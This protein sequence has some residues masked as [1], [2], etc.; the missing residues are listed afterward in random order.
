MPYSPKLLGE[1][2]TR[3]GRPTVSVVIPAR[4][5]AANLRLV[6]PTL[7][8]VHE[9]ILVDGHSCDG[10][11]EAA[12]TVLP[13]IRVVRQTRRGKGNALACGFAAATGDV[14]VMFD[15]DG[16]ADPA[17][18][19]RFVGALERGADLAKGSRFGTAAGPAGGSQDLT[20]WRRLGN[21]GLNLI[22]N[23]LFRTGFSDLCYGYNAFWRDLLPVLDLPAPERSTPDGRMLWGDGFEIETVI[24]C[25]IAAAELTITEV[26]S[27]ERRRVHG[28]SNLHPVRDGSRVLRTI[29]REYRRARRTPAGERPAGADVIEL[30][31]VARVVELWPTATD[32][33]PPAGPVGPDGQPPGRPADGALRA[34]DPVA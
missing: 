10:T 30:R 28:R 27:V 3:S 21:G 2:M 9:V 18:I 33:G 26:P 13:D 11:V 19:E 24:N 31:P 17:E 4:N 23:W 6:L 7:P 22:T 1:S 34:K 16:S 14:I 15:A 5:E 20:A 12:R 8:P 32:P 29:L 25:R